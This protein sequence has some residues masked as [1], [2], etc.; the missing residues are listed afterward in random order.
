MQWRSLKAG[1][2]EY[3]Q[4]H[5]R[6]NHK[7][8]FVIKLSSCRVFLRGTP[9]NLEVAECEGWCTECVY[10]IMALWV[11]IMCVYLANTTGLIACIFENYFSFL[12]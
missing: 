11:H 1:H 12:N 3:S 5:T 6:Q 2:S 4:A 7:S 9:N 10:A 8:W